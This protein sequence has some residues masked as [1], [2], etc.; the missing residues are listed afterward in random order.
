MS[1]NLPTG[2]LAKRR[3]S[4]LRKLFELEDLLQMVGKLLE[5]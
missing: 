2:E 5:E 1:A 3:V 4:S